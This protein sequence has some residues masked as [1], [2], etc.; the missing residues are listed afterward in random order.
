MALAFS[1]SFSSGVRPAK[2]TV[3]LPSERPVYFFL[4]YSN[5]AISAQEIAWLQ[6]GYM[7]KQR[8]R[9]HARN[10]RTLAERNREWRL[11]FAAAGLHAACPK[12]CRHFDESGIRIEVSERG[13]SSNREQNVDQR[14]QYEMLKLTKR[15]F[16]RGTV[17]LATG[18]GAGGTQNEGFQSVLEN[19]LEHGYSIE[20]FSW[21]RTLNHVLRS[22]VERHGRFIELD[23]FYPDITF[24]DGGRQATESHIL[25]RKIAKKGLVS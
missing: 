1:P 25:N 3:S 15:S 12:L 20:L 23:D 6:D 4:D 10:L 7:S 5:I 16:Q 18:D 17:V 24:I 22:W 9:L 8:V 2:L 21:R 11:G 13:N 19:L 14:I